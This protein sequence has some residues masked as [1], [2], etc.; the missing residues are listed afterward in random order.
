MGKKCDYK[1][2]PAPPAKVS[3]I[4][5]LIPQYVKVGGTNYRV[6]VG[7]ILRQEGRAEVAYL[8]ISEALIKIAENIDAQIAQ[9]SLIHEI[10][11]AMNT[12]NDLEL[13]HQTISTLAES[14]YQVLRDNDLGIKPRM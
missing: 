14:F 12:A 4:R 9:Q 3:E 7:D 5:K 11:E 2:E 6:V 1:I 8:Q 10:V 13:S